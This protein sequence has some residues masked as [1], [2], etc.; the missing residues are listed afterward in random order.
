MTGRV[1]HVSQDLGTTNSDTVG[2]GKDGL[3]DVATELETGRHV[4]EKTGLVGQVDELESV[5]EGQLEHLNQ[6]QPTDC[7]TLED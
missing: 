2:T 6:S 4:G 5:G 3:R 7:V 1:V